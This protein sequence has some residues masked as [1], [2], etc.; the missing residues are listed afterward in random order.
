MSSRGAL[1]KTVHTFGTG[2]VDQ[3]LLSGANF[4][5]G[6]AMIRFT[7]DVDYGQFV[8][9]QSAVLLLTSAQSAWL[10]P[11]C[12]VI[13]SRPPAVRQVMF[14]AVEASQSRFLRILVLIAAPVP[15]IGFLVG[16]WTGLLAMVGE[17]PFSPRGRRCNANTCATCWSSTGGRNRCCLR[18]WSTPW[19]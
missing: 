7:S 12:T 1:A 19:C 15:V 3:V 6:F 18:T 14:G 11:L 8:L 17:A 9:V 5:V 16:A 4:L 10:A 2:V 13:P